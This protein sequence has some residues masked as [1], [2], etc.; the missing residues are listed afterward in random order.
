MLVSVR[1]CILGWYCGNAMVLLEGEV[2]RTWLWRRVQGV[3]LVEDSARCGMHRMQLVGPQSL[4]KERGI[5]C[6]LYMLQIS[7]MQ[8]CAQMLEDWRVLHGAGYAVTS[9]KIA[10]LYPEDAS[11]RRDRRSWKSVRDAGHLLHL[12]VVKHTCSVARV[13]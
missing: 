1:V 13:Q 5:L 10:W 6:R 8:R 9:P 2:V 7:S 4:G 11:W 12:M 3:L